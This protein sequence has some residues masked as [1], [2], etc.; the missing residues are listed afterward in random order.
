MSVLE[1]IGYFFVWIAHFFI[2][3]WNSILSLL[4]WF[5]PV[6][7]FFKNTFDFLPGW[8]MVLLLVCI[9]IEIIIFILNLGGE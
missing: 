3:L 2:S 5:T 8:V 9:A 4:N 1:S 7:D 6:V